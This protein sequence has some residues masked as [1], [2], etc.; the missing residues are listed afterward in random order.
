MA[1][2]ADFI[3]QYVPLPSV[4]HYLT[5]Y[6]PGATPLSTTP[7]VVTTL[8]GYLATVFGI[9][10]LMKDRQ[11][12]KLNTLFRAHNAILSSGSLLL[13]LLMVEEISPIIF[14]KGPYY[15]ICAKESWTPVRVFLSLFTYKANDSPENG[16]LLH[17][18][19]LLQISRTL[20]YR[21]SRSQEKTSWL[22]ACVTMPLY[23]LISLSQRSC[24]YSIIRPLPYSAI[25]N[26][27]A[28]L[29]S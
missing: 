21:L 2:L 5:S 28:G 10:A 20:R 18:Q 4:P 11:P 12:Q 14:S 3:L 8:A 25:P 1:P 9:K 29:A 19:L 17:G 16:V 24:M 15:S 27:A 6:V 23:S 13:L 7:V 26:L 22:V